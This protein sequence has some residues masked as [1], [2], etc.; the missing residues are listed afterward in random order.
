[1]S[2]KLVIF[3]NSNFSKILKWYIDHDDTREVVAFCTESLFR[4]TNEFQGLPLERFEEIEYLYPPDQ[5]EI[6]LGVGYKNMNNLRKRI[7]NLCKEKGYQVATYIHSSSIVQSQEL[8]EGNI[9]LE[10]VVIGPFSKMG[11]GN[12]IMNNVSI[13]HDCII[14]NYNTFSGMAGLAGN[15][16]VGENCF[17]GKASVIKDNINIDDF[18]LIG[19]NAY[20]NNNTNKYMVI[21]ASKGIV[22]KDKVSTDFI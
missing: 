19:A 20:L 22:L 13:A 21:A 4:K 14:G 12:L 3:G 5:F 10:K 11:N 6:L 16:K 9:I 18:S 1:M 17:F 8:G 15:V 2:K 7:F